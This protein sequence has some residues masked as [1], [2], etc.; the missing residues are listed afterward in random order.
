MAVPLFLPQRLN[1]HRVLKNEVF[2]DATVVSSN[3][4][5]RIIG[6]RRKD[7]PVP[8]PIFDFANINL[9]LKPVLSFLFF[10]A[11]VIWPNACETLLNVS[12]Q[13][14]WEKKGS[15][16]KEPFKTAIT[17]HSHALYEGI[18]KE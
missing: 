15:L 1:V 13:T 2:F 6:S 17:Q 3:T 7:T 16:Y 11:L 14:G 8:F 5:A 18:L 4:P 12:Q 10:S 9:S